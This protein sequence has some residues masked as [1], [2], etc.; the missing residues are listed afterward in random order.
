MTRKTNRKPAFDSEKVRAKI[1]VDPTTDGDERG[2]SLFI[3][4]QKRSPGPKL[5]GDRHEIIRSGGRFLAGV[6]ILGRNAEPRRI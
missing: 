1:P 5:N 6:L 4:R 3:E 2:P